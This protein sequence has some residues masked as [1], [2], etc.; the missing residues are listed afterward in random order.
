MAPPDLEGLDPFISMIRALLFVADC[1]DLDGE[2]E[3]VPDLATVEH[4]MRDWM[5]YKS[6]IAQQQENESLNRM[7]LLA[8]CGGGCSWGSHPASVCWGRS[9]ETPPPGN[10][11]PVTLRLLLLRVE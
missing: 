6:V 2:Q 9:N 5:V 1:Y 7:S 10:T 8:G 11:P 4:I 3:Q